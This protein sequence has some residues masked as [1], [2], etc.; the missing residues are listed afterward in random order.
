MAW[1][2]LADARTSFQP[3]Q[4]KKA[5]GLGWMS[6]E[7]IP[8]NGQIKRTAVGTIKLGSSVGTRAPRIRPP[9]CKTGSLPH[10]AELRPSP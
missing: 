9:G 4:T 6:M 1:R 5:V 8:M 7:H 3:H 2:N 10:I